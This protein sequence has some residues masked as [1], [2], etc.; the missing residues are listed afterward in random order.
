M[1]MPLVKICG[2]CRPEDG[3]AAAES[4]ADFIGLIFASESKRRVDADQAV[5]IGEAARK[6]NEQIRIVGVFVNEQPAV[7]EAVARQAG[8]DLVQFHGDESEETIFRV[9]YP[10]IRALRVGDRLPPID[11]GAGIDWL[12]FDTLVEGARG[13]TGRV[14]EWKLLA[15]QPVK[16]PFFVSGGLHPGNVG[17]AIE[18]ARPDG[19]DVSSGVEDEPRVKNH[20]KI[21]EFI[22][23]VRR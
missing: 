20:E 1:S 22:R 18:A 3:V 12:L 19:V 13:G 23:Q 2:I 9:S 6:R 4:G 16:R 14:F 5:L 11:S 21:R 17:Q 10:S 8:L 7:I 15:A